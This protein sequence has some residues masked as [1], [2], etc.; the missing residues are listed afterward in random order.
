[1]A[2]H[3][4][5]INQG[6]AAP[7]GCYNPHISHFYHDKSWI[8][9]SLFSGGI[10]RIG[11]TSKQIERLWDRNSLMQNGSSCWTYPLGYVLDHRLI[12]PK[13]GP[14]Q[15]V[16]AWLHNKFNSNSVIW[17]VRLNV[18]PF[19]EDCWVKFGIAKTKEESHI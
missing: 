8:F 6:R 11:I 14:L 2:R 19:N 17:L 13:K 5:V 10:A 12:A 16:T 4:L 3:S 9:S 1:M 18:Y 7:I 15:V